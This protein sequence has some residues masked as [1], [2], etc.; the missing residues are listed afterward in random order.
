MKK[1]P[2][3]TLAVVF[4]GGCLLCATAFAGDTPVQNSKGVPPA[5]TV[6]KQPTQQTPSKSPIQTAVPT[7]QLT[8]VQTSTPSKFPSP[9][10]VTQAEEPCGL[11]ARIRARR[12]ARMQTRMAPGER[13]VEVRAPFVRVTNRR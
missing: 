5:P 1:F 8:P 4:I 7:K 11:F 2:L 12:A 3:S 10:Q 13:G 6:T 9:Q